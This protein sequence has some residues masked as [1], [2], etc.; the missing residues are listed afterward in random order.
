MF[1][2]FYDD[3]SSGSILIMM[4]FGALFFRFLALGLIELLGSVSLVFTKSGKISV[5]IS[6]NIFSLLLPFFRGSG[7]T[8][9][10]LTT[11]LQHLY[12][13]HLHCTDEDTEACRG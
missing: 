4:H 2:S 3:L 5:I 8:Y 12:S 10:F 7:Y 13:Y 11:T 9:I 1:C 6:L